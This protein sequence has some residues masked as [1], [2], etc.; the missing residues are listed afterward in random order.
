[1]LLLCYNSQ[2]ISI[3]FFRTYYVVQAQHS[4]QQQQQQQQHP[5]QQQQEHHE[6]HTF[7]DLI[8]K[9]NS[10]YSL[11]HF[12][13]PEWLTE[14]YKHIGLLIFG[15]GICDLTTSITKYSVGRLRPHF[16]A[17]SL[18]KFFNLHPFHVF[19]GKQE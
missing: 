19:N 6:Q 7:D 4:N 9:N 5:N 14:C 1:M 12:N 15:A 18:R 10:N 8:A 16:L 17:V 13:V 3:E 2:I 11:W